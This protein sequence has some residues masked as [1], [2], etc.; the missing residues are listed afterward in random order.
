MLHPDQ[1]KKIRDTPI[2]ETIFMGSGE[3]ARVE[4]ER[5][6]SRLLSAFSLLSGA[7]Q[8]PACTEKPDPSR[9]GQIAMA[10][11]EIRAIVDEIATGLGVYATATEV[12]RL[13]EHK[14]DLEGILEY[15]FDDCDN[16]FQELAE[17][18]RHRLATYKALNELDHHEHRWTV[19]HDDKK[20]LLRTCVCGMEQQLVSDPGDVDVVTDK[21]SPADSIAKWLL[22]RPCPSC[23]A[24]GAFVIGPDVLYSCPLI[25]SVR[26][27]SCGSVHQLQGYGIARFETDARVPEP[28]W[29]DS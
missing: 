8:L 16:D 14:Q 4:M 9:A 13:R 17:K 25:Y 12:G 24:I 6:S 27:S 19:R 18:A 23:K 1:K 3:F 11:H 15:S 21:A 5:L 10:N 20:G 29:L 7:Q 28:K 2:T 26:C 22:S